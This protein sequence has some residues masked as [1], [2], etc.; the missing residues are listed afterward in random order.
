MSYK[1]LRP[2]LDKVARCR[3]QRRNWLLSARLVIVHWF[4]WSLLHVDS[5]YRSH[6]S[7]TDWLQSL[8]PTPVATW[9][10]I[11]ATLHRSV[12]PPHRISPTPQ[13][14]LHWIYC[15]WVSLAGL[16][17]KAISSWYCLTRR[18]PVKS[19][20][21]TQTT[22]LSNHNFPLQHLWLPIISSCAESYKLTIPACF[23]HRL[24][25]LFVCDYS[26]RQWVFRM[27]SHKTVPRLGM[28]QQ[29]LYPC[30]FFSGHV[31]LIIRV[32]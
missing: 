2:L 1:I 22:A 5:H 13:Y 4:L 29:V 31:M 17:L 19:T 30:N 8:V 16:Q 6:T 14:S 7:G 28:E 23:S 21:F 32:Y 9:L 10:P 15:I 24:C 25:C 26:P 11:Q 12:G 20:V 27:T 18:R 3:R